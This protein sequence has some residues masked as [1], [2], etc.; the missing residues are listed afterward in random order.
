MPI[1]SKA[2]QPM[3]GLHR[4]SPLQ[5][6]SRARIVPSGGQSLPGGSVEACV[7]IE[8]LVSI[9][10]LYSVIAVQ[11]KR[12]LRFVPSLSSEMLDRLRRSTCHRVAR[13]SLSAT[14]NSVRTDAYA[15]T[16]GPIASHQVFRSFAQCCRCAIRRW[17]EHDEAA[18]AAF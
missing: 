16:A 5:A 17:L 18:D 7:E 12:A 9:P 4:D 13:Y 10:A 15:R 1:Q 2:H 14:E 11:S 8:M 3:K 6:F